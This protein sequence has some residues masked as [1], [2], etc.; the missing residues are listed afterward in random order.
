MKGEKGGGGG[1]V[2]ERKSASFS[3]ALAKVSLSFSRSIDQRDEARAVAHEAR[4]Q[5]M[6]IFLT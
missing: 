1:Q 2:F 4:A 3:L 6:S 5:L